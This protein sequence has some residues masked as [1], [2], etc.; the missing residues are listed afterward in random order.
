[1]IH[2]A[3]LSQNQTITLQKR[4]QPNQCM[5]KT[6]F[7]RYVRNLWLEPLAT[8]TKK[9]VQNSSDKQDF[10][11]FKAAGLQS[12]LKSLVKFLS[13]SSSVCLFASFSGKLQEIL[14]HKVQC[15][16]VIIK[17]VPLRFTTI[18][19]SIGNVKV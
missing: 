16:L 19:L 2:I 7:V 10:L 4:I 13:V 14:F 1:M 6:T 15:T 17:I 8:R 11:N 3:P 18:F 9:N 12:F 5:G